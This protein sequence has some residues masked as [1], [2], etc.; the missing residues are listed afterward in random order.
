MQQKGHQKGFINIH[1]DKPQESEAC[2]SI[3]I[4]SQNNQ[5]SGSAGVWSRAQGQMML[6]KEV[7]FHFSCPIFL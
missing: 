6:N 2:C 3:E 7:T 5:V 1:S 4:R